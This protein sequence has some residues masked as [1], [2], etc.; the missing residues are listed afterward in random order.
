MPRRSEPKSIRARKKGLTGSDGSSAGWSCARA[1]L[2]SRDSRA[3]HGWREPMASHPPRAQT[4]LRSRACCP[5]RVTL[6]T[7]GM[8]RVLENARLPNRKKISRWL[9]LA[10]NRCE[11]VRVDKQF[12]AGFRPNCGEHQRDDEL[13]TEPIL[14]VARRPGVGRGVHHLFQKAIMLHFGERRL[15]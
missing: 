2:A 14:P 4:A 10:Q 3:R 5:L 7:D 1:T 6:T 13:Q 15:V 9:R 11:I 12:R 8:Q